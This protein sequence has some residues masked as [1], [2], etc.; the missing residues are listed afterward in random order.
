MKTLVLPLAFLSCV[1]L[2]GESMLSEAEGEACTVVSGQAPRSEKDT[3]NAA[4]IEAKREASGR[5]ATRVK[6][7]VSTDLVSGKSGGQEQV[8]QV[9]KTVQTAY[10]NADTKE[11]EV[12]QVEVRDDPEQGRC[13]KV[14]VR[15]EVTPRPDALEGVSA[16]MQEDPTLPLTVKIWTDRSKGEGAAIYHKGEQMRLYLRGNKPFYARVIYS[17]TDGQTL[18]ILPNPHR[19]E[20]Y[21]Q[22]GTL[23]TLPDGKD[24]FV[25]EV[26]PPFGAERITVYAS[27]QPLGK[28]KTES[29]GSVFVVDAAQRGLI[30][31]QLRG[32]KLVKTGSGSQQPAEFSEQ[33]VD[34]ITMDGI[35][36]K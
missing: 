2:A 8:V 31:Q 12:R 6:S 36:A 18:Q 7:M 1:A 27:D 23:Y 10:V 21:F 17:M 26:A 28:I 24:Q 13:I 33:S 34:V 32:I 29:A 25:M 22:G 11:L 4:I 20:H 30:A 19:H 9:A 35:T 15:V 3:R 14:F 5:V 16:A